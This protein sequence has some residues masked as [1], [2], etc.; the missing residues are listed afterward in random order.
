MRSVFVFRLAVGLFTGGFAVASPCKPIPVTTTSGEISIVS[1]ETASA[2]SAVSSTTETSAVSSTTD[3]SA[4]SVVSES[5]V[6]LSASSSLEVVSSTLFEVSVTSMFDA[7][8]TTAEPTTTEQTTTEQTTTGATTSAAMP[9]FTIYASSE[10]ALDGASLETYNNAGSVAVFNHNP[11]FGSAT[12]RSYTIDSEGR[13]INDQGF[14]LCAYYLA[15]NAQLDAPASVGTCTTAQPKNPFL[16]CELSG[17]ELQC[18]IAARTCVYNPN[19]EPTCE[20]TGGMWN[21]WSVGLVYVGTGLM[22]GPEDTPSTYDRIRVLVS[23]L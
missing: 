14:F 17:L 21:T 15:N 18:G 2:T 19:G 13:L 7:E 6:E 3:V 8:S 11:I 16:R 22:I 4:T 10:S 23:I 1:S 9:T 20:E 5:S 12:A